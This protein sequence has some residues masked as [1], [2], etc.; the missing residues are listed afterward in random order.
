MA[1]KKNSKIR[2]NLK[3]V[4]QVKG[5]LRKLPKVMEEFLEKRL[6]KSLKLVKVL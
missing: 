3:T 2:K 6:S 4:K 1:K 5:L